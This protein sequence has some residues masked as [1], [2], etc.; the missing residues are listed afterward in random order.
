MTE[1]DCIVGDLCRSVPH[2]IGAVLCDFDG[3]TVVSA[4][5]SAPIPAAAEVRAR[6]QMPRSLASSIAPRELLMRI[7]GAEPCALLRLFGEAGPSRGA[8]DLMDLEMRYDEVEMLVRRLPNEYYLVLVLRRPAI[9][10][11]ARREVRRAGD[12]LEPHVA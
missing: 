10:A 9:T 5:G 2:S 6:E 3:E 4:L 7:G 11:R 8:G 1:L 12:L